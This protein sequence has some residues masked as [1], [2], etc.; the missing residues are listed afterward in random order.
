MSPQIAIL[1][2]GYIGL[3]HAA[4]VAAHPRAALAALCGTERSRAQVAAAAQEYGA[5]R[6]LTD[7]RAILEDPAIDIVYICTPNAQH[8]DQTVAAL[9]AGKHVFVEKPMAT[10]LEDCQRMVEAVDRT[11]QKLLVGQI[12]RFSPIFMA[13]K[14]MVDQGDLGEVFFVEG[15]Y[16]HNLQSFLELPGHDW[17]LDPGHPHFPL[18]GGGCHPLDLMRWV[19]GE[20]EEVTCYATKKVLRDVPWEDTYIVTLKFVNGAVGKLFISLGAQAP[21]A[22]NFSVYGTQ[23]TVRNDELFLSRIGYLEDFMKMPIPIQEEHPN[24]PQELDH[25][26]AVIE[27]DLPPLID[28]RD[29]ACTTATCLAMIEA[30]ET[31]RPA[32]V[33]RDF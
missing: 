7:Y 3:Q 21:Y 30:V 4:A 15:D 2:T 1:G 32:S 26:L 27:H 31:G 29:G 8:A 23:G 33:V 17:W 22:L 16:I 14:Q 28:V 6:A 24:C 10:T 25:F 11:G 9:D 20:V 19:A 18:P 12:C 5:A 13:I